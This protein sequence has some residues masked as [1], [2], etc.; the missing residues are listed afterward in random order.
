MPANRQ[1]KK[2]TRNDVFAFQNMVTSYLIDLQ[3][4]R[5]GRIRTGDPLIPNQMR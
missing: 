4:G 3:I 1:T 2:I 5:S